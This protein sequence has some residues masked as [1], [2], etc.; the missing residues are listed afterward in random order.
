MWDLL[1]VGL[2][3]GNLAPE[4]I[5]CLSPAGRSPPFS[6]DQLLLLQLNA[7]NHRYP[8]RQAAPGRGSGSDRNPGSGSAGAAARLL[9]MRAPP[10]GRPAPAA[11]RLGRDP[12]PRAPA[13]RRAWGTRGLRAGAGGGQLVAVQAETPTHGSPARSEPLRRSR[14]ALHPS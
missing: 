4:L 9:V 6:G 8:R 10:A 12:A 5:A 13:N 3:D 11:E 2:A 1:S 14:V 7:K